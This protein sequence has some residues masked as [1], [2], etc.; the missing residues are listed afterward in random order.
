MV[1]RARDAAPAEATSALDQLC[2]AYWQPLYAYARCAGL[3]PSDAQDV[4][5]GFFLHVIGGR[6]LPSVDPAKG[7]FRSFML[8][9]VR[10]YMADERDRSR[11]AKRGGGAELLSLDFTI[12]ETAFESQLAQHESP[13]RA[14]DRAW[15]LAVLA[16][17]QSQLAQEY[18]AA[19]KEAVHNALGPASPELTYAAAGTRLGM[20]ESAVKTAAFR[21]RRRYRDLIRDEIAQT[22]STPEELNQELESLFQALGSA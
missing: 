22:V 3:S 14:F 5:Q 16:R 12:A 21:L 6:V 15:A 1:L 17:A 8:T 4:V 20:T 13:D 11:A 7:R 9:S 10:N 18:R 2:L 19:G